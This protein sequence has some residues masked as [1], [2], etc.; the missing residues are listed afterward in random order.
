MLRLLYKISIFLIT[1]YLIFINI[2]YFTGKKYI[3]TIVDLFNDSIFRLFYF[4]LIGIISLGYISGGIILAVLLTV[5][6]INTILF[7]CKKM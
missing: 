2:S 6:F 5:I 7:D 1:L 4:I 3:L